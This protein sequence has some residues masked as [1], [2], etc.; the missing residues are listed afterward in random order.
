MDVIDIV[1]EIIA[2]KVDISNLKEEDELASLGL[3]SL[4]L[5][6]VMMA[7]EDRCSIEFSSEEISEIKTLGD[8]VKL[9]KEKTN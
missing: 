7:I 1:K 4:D 6:E 5:V 8:M 9:I 3:D 2:E